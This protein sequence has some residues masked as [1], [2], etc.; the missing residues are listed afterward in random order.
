[1]HIAVLFYQPRAV[2]TV[3]PREYIF[4]VA[5]RSL[6]R[7][8]ERGTG[9]HLPKTSQ[10]GQFRDCAPHITKRTKILLLVVI[11]LKVGTC[12]SDQGYWYRRHAIRQ[13][14]ALSPGHCLFSASLH[15]H[16]GYITSDIFVS[17]IPHASAESPALSPHSSNWE[18]FPTRLGNIYEVMTSNNKNAW[19]R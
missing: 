5:A 17:V 1:M 11:V 6:K 3:T 19:T 16:R 8:W 10:T 14:S 4:Q 12:W 18:L 2:H 7:T 13:D 9:L 15:N